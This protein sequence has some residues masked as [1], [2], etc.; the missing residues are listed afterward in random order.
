ME[1]KLCN[2]VMITSITAEDKPCEDGDLIYAD[3]YRNDADLKTDY[4][5]GLKARRLILD[6]AG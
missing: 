3:K 1:I 4:M 6:Y 5:N 2:V